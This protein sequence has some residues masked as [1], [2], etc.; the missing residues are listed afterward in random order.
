MTNTVQ[1]INDKF[2]SRMVRVDVLGA[3]KARPVNPFANR[4]SHDSWSVSNERNMAPE[5]SALTK[6][7]AVYGGGAVFG[8]LERVVDTKIE[9]MVLFDTRA[10]THPSTGLRLHTTN[11][12]P[13]DIT[14]EK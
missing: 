3:N 2:E 6:V 4:S 9:Q 7:G 1:D 14:N 13:S 12:L 10:I 11:K 8:S 5:V